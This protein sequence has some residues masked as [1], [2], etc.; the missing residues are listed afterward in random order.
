[1]PAAVD[2]NPLAF[3]RRADRRVV[4]GVAGGFA[5]QH[6]LD[7]V[8]VRAALVVLS[9]AGGLGIVLYVLGHVV[10]ETSRAPLRAAQPHDHRRNLSVAAITL[11]LVLIMRSI[12]LWIDDLVM[13]V[14][15]LV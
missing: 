4:L 7:A 11:G 10:A 1:M 2:V 14:V 5:D 8:V 3:D 13:V 15:I 6:G 12:G 9:F